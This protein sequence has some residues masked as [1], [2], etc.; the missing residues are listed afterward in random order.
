M[1]LIFDAGAWDLDWNM[2]FSQDMGFLR[3]GTDIQGMVHTGEMTMRYLGIVRPPPLY[4]S[5][6]S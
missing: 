5:H 6:L 1:R 4:F 3:T 2:T